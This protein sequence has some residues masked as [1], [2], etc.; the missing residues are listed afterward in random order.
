MKLEVLPGRKGDCMLLHMNHA[1]Q[2]RLVLIDGGPAGVWDDDLSLRLEELQEERAPDGQLVIDLVIVS[3][4]DDDHINGVIRLLDA[5]EHDDFPV[6]ISELWHNSFDRILGNDETLATDSDTALAS[7][8]SQAVVFLEDDDHDRRD[9]ALVL[10]SIAQGDRLLAQALRLGIPV[11]LTFGGDLIVAEQ[12]TQPISTLES[13]VTV[14]GPLRED[15]QELQRK[16]DE[17]LRKSEE[18][19]PTAS[20][21]AALTDTSAANLSSIVL[22]V[23]AGGRR[24]LLTGD[25]RSDRFLEAMGDGPHAYDI[26]KMPH[27]GSDRNVDEVFF[28]T[29]VGETYVFSGDG[30]HGNPERETVAMLLDHRPAETKPTLVF[31]YAIEDID[32]VRKEVWDKQQRRNARRGR[33]VVDWDHGTMS[34]AAL[35]E[36]RKDEADIVV[37]G[38]DGL[39]PEL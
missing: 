28:R 23:E 21:L 12:P 2:E 22:T 7:V 4:V 14:E 24:I 30:K 16:F 34:L 15:V 6:K 35:L 18:D 9:A 31:T 10:A 29:V 13:N 39:L 26:I 38:E 20:L 19:K 5:I 25:A 33:E 17:W 32:A 8:A 36:G 37:P 27:H 11:N 1:G 3:H